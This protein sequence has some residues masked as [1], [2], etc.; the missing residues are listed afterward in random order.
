MI[1]MAIVAVFI[2][3]YWAFIDNLTVVLISLIGIGFSSTA[4]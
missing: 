3:L 2:G 4:R 1:F